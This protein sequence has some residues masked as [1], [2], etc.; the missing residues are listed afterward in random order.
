VALFDRI[1]SEMLQARRQ[2]DTLKLNALGLLKSELV[3]AS[4]EP[5]ASGGIDDALVARMA[6]RELKRRE[7]AVDAYRGAGREEAAQREEREAEVLREYLPAQMSQAELER[8]IGAMIAELKP[9]DPGAFGAV[10]RTATVRLAGRAEGS[11]IAAT[12]RRLLA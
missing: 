2:R 7:E 10:M 6:R 5:G 3:N 1:E 9:A 4:K 8:E 11:R 12:A